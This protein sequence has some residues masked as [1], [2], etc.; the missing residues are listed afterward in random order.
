MNL[1]QLRKQAKQLV[2]A[3]RGG[4]AD[5][6]AR[7]GGREPT[8]A[9]AQLVVARG[10]GYSSWPGLV[11]AAEASVDAFVVA[12]TDN[13]RQRAER[14]LAARPAIERDRWGDSCSGA[15]GTA[16][17]VPPAGRGIG[18]RSGTSATPASP[19]TS[20]RASSCAAA[21]TRTRA[22]TTSTGR[23]PRSTAPPACTTIRI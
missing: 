23:S 19:R 15:A 5:A 10:Y 11:A 6:L 8:L 12:A 16:I 9:S 20:S 4:D 1:E 21:P 22:S 14:L 2:R 7:L 17:R 13:R 3:A 18:R